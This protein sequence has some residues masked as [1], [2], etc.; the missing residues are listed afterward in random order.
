MA[1]KNGLDV[2]DSSS[3][4]DLDKSQ[5]KRDWLGTIMLKQVQGL[6]L[7]DEEW[8]F[9]TNMFIHA[10][11]EDIEKLARAS[12]VELQ[13]IGAEARNELSPDVFWG[14]K[15]RDA[16]LIQNL[17]KTL[18]QGRRDDSATRKNNLST[19]NKL[20]RDAKKKGGYVT[21]DDSV[22]VVESDDVI[23]NTKSNE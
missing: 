9:Y 12:I 22:K 17:L 15:Q 16:H 13:K 7:T 14:L 5:A 18:K 2:V 8:S 19:F 6:P 23:D 21:G 11:D 1:D 4:T 3:S 20:V 10:K